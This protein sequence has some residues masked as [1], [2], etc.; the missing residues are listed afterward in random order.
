MKKLYK[1][2]VF[3]GTAEGRE[4]I[5]FFSSQQQVTVT[6]LVATEYGRLL[7]P[8]SQ[9][10][11]ILCGRLDREEMEKLLAAEK[12]DLVIDTTHPYASA[13]T[14]NIARACAGAGAEYLRL[15]REA[16]AIPEDAVA[17]PDA[18]A[19][20]AYLAAR[21]GNILLTVGS[22]ELTHF[23]QI[24]GFS[25]RV[26][27]RVLPAE[28]SL[29][30]CKQ[31]GLPASHIFAM[32]GP[33]SAEMN[34]ALLRAVSARYL[35]T[36]EGGG[37]GGFTEKML[38]AKKAGAVPVVIGRPPQREGL[39][40]SETVGL[41]CRRYHLSRKPQVSVAGIGPG[42]AAMMTREVEE[43]IR[44]ADCL[45][46][47][48]RMVESAARPG[49][50]VYEAISPEK[51]RVIIAG[52]PE[53]GRF[54]V[55]L[56]GDIGFFSGAKRLLPLLSG[57]EV[58]ALPGISSLC[59]LCARLGCSYEDVVSVSLHGREHDIVP[60]VRRHPRAFVLVGGED[61]I[62]SLCQELMNAGLGE[63][64]LSVGERLGYPD[65]QITKGTAAELAGRHFHPL[66]A[67]LIENDAAWIPAAAFGLPDTAFLRGGPENP[68]PMTKSEVRAVCLSKLR[69]TADA[70]CWDIGAGTGSV[71]IEMALQAREGKV[72]A[73]EEKEN[74]F[75]LLTQN[76]KRF[77]TKNLT[78][79]LGHAPEALK[80]L[81]APTHA[82][83]GGS[84]GK[85]REMISLL[86]EKNPQVRIV[87]SAI[88]L[89]TIG[90]L[91][92]CLSAFPFSETE[93][94][95]LSLAR[96]RRAGSHRLMMGQNP[97]YIFT[98]QGGD[99]G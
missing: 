52:H 62:A 55:L 86:L 6:A 64:R 96:S 24:E 3:A 91:T 19:A 61:G 8:E 90:E 27:A 80:Q 44:Q 66:S 99:A 25:E 81:P 89:E 68:V 2:C 48:R 20:A 65:E 76:C 21:E 35:V 26:Y 59:C 18:G 22:K 58:K 97:V 38:A 70:V 92:A 78:A 13:A 77:G 63:V 79:V 7:L 47:A 15:C 82:F 23:S 83:I 40:L 94:V 49:Q 98:M 29:R 39:S 30:L 50:T 34:T 45:I 5:E 9:N 11:R 67:V 14:E 88:S 72:Y 46:G 69:L 1:I 16:D 42:G 57:Y 32:Q 37:S 93:A 84:S 12:F 71:S 53:Y 75:Q 10:L 54:A 4:M 85:L 95:S 60:D 31:A 56:S 36:K 17:V 43:A 73:V 41:L 74:A 51:I 33:F 28:E 87:A